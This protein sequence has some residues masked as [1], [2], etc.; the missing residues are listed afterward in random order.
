MKTHKRSKH[1]FSPMLTCKLYAGLSPCV[2]VLC[3]R[4]KFLISGTPLPI[5]SLQEH[6]YKARFDDTMDVLILSLKIK[7]CVSVP[8]LLKCK[9][10]IYT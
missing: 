6:L 2:N 7:F 10:V 9:Q 4:F 8:E 5:S 1:F 3:E